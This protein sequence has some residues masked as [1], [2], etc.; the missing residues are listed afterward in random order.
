MPTSKKRG[1]RRKK[2]CTSATSLSTS[3]TLSGVGLNPVLSDDRPASNHL[4]Y[5]MALPHIISLLDWSGRQTSHTG[6]FN[7]A[8]SVLVSNW[9]RRLADS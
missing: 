5:G 2:I 6:R 3:R 4:A 8:G 1:P 9:I 7:F